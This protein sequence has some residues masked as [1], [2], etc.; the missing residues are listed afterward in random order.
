M[1]KAFFALL[2][3]F[4]AAGIAGLYAWIGFGDVRAPSHGFAGLSDDRSQAFSVPPELT[5]Q[6]E[7]AWPGDAPGDSAVPEI[8]PVI[9]NASEKAFRPVVRS[10]P[11]AATT[12]SQPQPGPRASQRVL[13][14]AL[15]GELKRVGCYKGVVDGAWLG[16]SQVAMRRFLQKVNAQLP[17]EQPDPALLSLLQAADNNACRAGDKDPDF[18]TIVKPAPTGYG[19]QPLATGT[20]S[21]ASERPDVSRPQTSVVAADDTALPEP[22]AVGRTEPVTPRKTYRARDRSVESLFKHPLGGGF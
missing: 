4:F 2:T 21:A 15:Q 22:M 17:V 12:S 14:M 19:T 7:E 11:V 6:V 1:R 16:A 13:A 5:E 10:K 8:V 20:V 18:V 3:L 9:V